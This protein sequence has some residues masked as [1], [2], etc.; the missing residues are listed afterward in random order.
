M[1]RRKR[2]RRRTAKRKH[3]VRGRLE[4]FFIENLTGDLG[5][6]VMLEREIEAMNR[7][8]AALKSNKAPKEKKK[9]EKREKLQPTASTSKATSK[10]NK[11]S[12]SSKKKSKKPITENDV[13]TFEQKKDL[14]ESIAKLDEQKLERVIQIIHEGVPEIRDVRAAVFCLV[15]CDFSSTGDSRVLKKLSWR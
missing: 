15:V 8:I 10:Q 1:K 3:N 4:L 5:T 2:R 13:L 9:K 11:T 7:N 6:I 12:S 14:S